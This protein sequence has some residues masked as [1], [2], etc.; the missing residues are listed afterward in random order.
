VPVRIVVDQAAGGAVLRPG[1]SV[2]VRVDLKSPG[3]QGFAEAGLG[4]EQIAAL[5]PGV[6]AGQ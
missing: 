6:V 5:D 2:E 3:G 1:L 4:A